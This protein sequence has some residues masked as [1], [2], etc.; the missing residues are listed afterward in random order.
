[1]RCRFHPLLLY[2][3]PPLLYIP[4]NHYKFEKER[5][6]SMTQVRLP[7][8]P[9]DRAI[10]SVPILFTYGCAVP[11]SFT[12]CFAIQNI[13]EVSRSEEGVENTGS[14]G[15]RSQDSSLPLLITDEIGGVSIGRGD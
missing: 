8:G 4:I 3:P 1:M 13:G 5:H 11:R 6:Q 10:C 7:F 12:G 14:K 9:R 15:G 2:V